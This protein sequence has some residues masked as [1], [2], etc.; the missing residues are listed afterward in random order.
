MLPVDEVATGAL[1]ESP[2]VGVDDDLPLFDSI[3]SVSQA[4]HL[5]LSLAFSM[6]HT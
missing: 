5:V 3:F 2:L 4:S 1:D 6:R